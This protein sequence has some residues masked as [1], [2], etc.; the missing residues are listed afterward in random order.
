MTSYYVMAKI[1]AM[2]FLLL[3]ADKNLFLAVLAPRSYRTISTTKLG[4]YSS[5]SLCLN[6]PYNMISSCTLT[7][8][9]LFGRTMLLMTTTSSSTVTASPARNEKIR[10]K[11]GPSLWSFFIELQRVWTIEI[12]GSQGYIPRMVIPSFA[13]WSPWA[14]KRKWILHQP[15]L[16]IIHTRLKKK[17]KKA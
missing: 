2:F 8:R 12:M 7:L 3:S 17:K 16:A 14:W 6:C 15:Q 10:L 5:L 11:V 1:K 13:L 9:V 4:G